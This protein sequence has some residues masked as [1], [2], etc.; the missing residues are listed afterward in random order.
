[1]TISQGG[2]AL[3]TLP[4]A[5]LNP[6]W[7]HSLAAIKNWHWN[8]EHRQLEMTLLDDAGYEVESVVAV[9]E[10]GIYLSTGPQLSR[11]YDLLVQR[12][13]RQGARIE[14]DANHITMETDAFLIQIGRAHP[15]PYIRVVRRA[16]GRL[17]NS[18]PLGS[19]P[20]RDALY[21]GQGHASPG[22]SWLDVELSPGEALYGLGERF[23]QFNLRGQTVDLWAEDAF[24]LEGQESYINIPWLISTAGWGMLV[25]TAAATR[26][27]V[28]QT[29]GSTL[30]ILAAEPAFETYVLF[31]DPME[32]LRQYFRLTGDPVVPPDWSFGLWMSR[33]GYASEEEMLAVVDR[34]QQDNTAVSVI[35][36]DPLWLAEKNG[37]TCPFKWDR[38][39]FPDPEGMIQRLKERDV[40]LSLWINP[41]VPRD[42]DVYRQARDR[43]YLVLTVDGTPARLPRFDDDSAVVDFTNPAACTWYQG[44]LQPLLAMGVAVFKTDFGE[45]APFEEVRYFNGASGKAGHNLNALYYQKTVF[46]ATEAAFPGQALVWGRSGYMGSQRFP[47]QWGGD[48]G[49]TWEYMQKSLRGAL[50]YAMSGA[51]FMAFDVGGFAGTPTPEI[52]L[53]WSAM[54][55]FFSHIRAHG[56]TPREPAAFG[57]EAVRVFRSFS[58]DRE[59]LMPYILDAARASAD[60]GLPLIRPLVLTH[61]DD[62]AVFGIDFEYYLGPDILVAPTLTDRPASL[63]YL[64]AGHW[65]SLYH[66]DQEW[67]GGRWYRLPAPPLDEIWCFM[68]SD[69][70]P[71][72]ASCP[73]VLRP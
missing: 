14:E 45:T 49:I 18:A 2:S 26:W 60:A 69:R 22:M 13:A 38:D 11:P 59:R 70:P 73:R 57:E 46:E 61:P 21:R 43:G 37:H 17:W 12:P 1:M 8:T 47:I 44:L 27:D 41:F 54:G 58:Q 63:V 34:L 62:P 36:L 67:E 5:L 53:R 72:M 28:A 32:L 10:G 66:P 51:C 20:F 29:H 55:F 42:S 6:Q 16:D 23:N 39:Q 4:Q 24:G 64:P 3:T 65:Q 33:W 48:T 71:A 68:R 56:T 19:G 35:H 40:R 15:E 31:G 9:V 52:Y 50:S 25:P 7:P 30:R